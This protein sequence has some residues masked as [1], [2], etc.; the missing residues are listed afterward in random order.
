MA[1]PRGLKFYRSFVTALSCHTLGQSQAQWTQV[2]GLT[3]S[4]DYQSTLLL[5]TQYMSS[6]ETIQR[7]VISILA[8][9]N[10]IYARRAWLQESLP[11]CYIGLLAI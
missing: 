2:Y 7:L 3:R 10:Q 6:M 11:F 8:C 1:V 4:E 5:F 9:L